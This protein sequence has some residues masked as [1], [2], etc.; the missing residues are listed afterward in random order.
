VPYIYS[1]A[2]LRRRLTAIPAK[3]L[4]GLDPGTLRT[5]LL[6]LYGAGLRITE[7]LTLNEA[8]VD[9]EARLLTIRQS[10][11]FKTPWV[12]ISTQLGRVLAHY[13]AHHP[14]RAAD[15]GRLFFRSVTGEPVR[16]SA[17]ERAFRTLRRAAGV[18]RSD[19]ARY[20]PRLHDLRHAFAVHRLLA[21][22]RQG[23]DVQRLLPALATYLGHV[24]VAATQRSYRDTFVLLLPFAAKQCRQAVDP[25]KLEHLSPKL[26]R[27]FLQHL[28]QRRRCAP[29]TVNQPL[30]ALRAWARFVGGHSPEH[31]A[32]GGQVRTLAFRKAAPP[33]MAYLERTEMQA[34][35]DA[36]DRRQPHQRRD[37]ALLLFL[38]NTGA[39]A[40]EAVD[41][42][43]G[44]VDG[45]AP[46]VTLHGKGNKNRR[47]PLWPTTLAVLKELAGSRPGPERVFLNRQ[48]RPLT[49]FGLHKAPLPTAALRGQAA[50]LSEDRLGGYLCGVKNGVRPI[51]RPVARAAPHN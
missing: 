39:R 36:P 46:A 19:G 16:R 44:D 48:G 31:A 27:A 20:Q 47:C 50:D 15:R 38:Y 28:A 21:G 29:T 17:A 14:R 5:L 13:R 2:E 43:I 1:R 3:P 23:T 33:L 8:D 6:L 32:W 42:T 25:L 40:S 18:Q 34:L 11:F 12:P 30:A 35:L 24:D 37:R 49:R 45:A 41:L 51:P 22:Y 26:L 7:A 10:K 9:R 4:A